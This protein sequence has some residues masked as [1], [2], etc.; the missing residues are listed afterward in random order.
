MQLKTRSVN[1]RKGITMKVSLPRQGIQ[2]KVA[3]PSA[4]ID[5]LETVKHYLTHDKVEIKHKHH[6]SKA[7]MYVFFLIDSSGS[8][9]KDKQIA[10]IKGLVAQ[11]ITR[12]KSKRIKYAAVALNNG[13][14][15]L[16][17]APTL[18]AEEL[19]NT[20]A[21]LTTGGKT[22][23]RAG[24]SM[25]GQLVKTNIQEHV[26]LYIFTDGK[27][28]AGNTDDPFRDAVAFYRQYLTGIK[29]TTIIDNENGF[30]KLGLAKKLATSISGGY[31]HIQQNITIPGDQLR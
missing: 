25:I 9:V 22:N 6:R 11:T 26:S 15:E 21:Q 27:I 13:D 17:S 28:N 31:Q 23:M 24:F 20:L 5:I 19:I 16:L 30:V 12:Y 29:Q 7:S 18:H 3:A 2:Q 8:M 1:A 10:Y 14:A 4:Q